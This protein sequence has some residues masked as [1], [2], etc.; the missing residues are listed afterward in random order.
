M[1]DFVFVMIRFVLHLIAHSL[2]LSSSC[3]SY[4]K[5][6]D[7]YLWKINQGTSVSFILSNIFNEKDKMMSE[8]KSAVLRPSSR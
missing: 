3:L 8:M 7:F 6:D 4:H 2:C 1:I 5:F